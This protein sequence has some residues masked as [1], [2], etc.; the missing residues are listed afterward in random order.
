MPLLYHSLNAICVAL[1]T[2][3]E[4]AQG[5]GVPLCALGVYGFECG[6]CVVLHRSLVLLTRP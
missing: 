6:V 3:S 2:T 1:W 4:R 5:V